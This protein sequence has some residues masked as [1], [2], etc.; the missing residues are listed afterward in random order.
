MYQIR[1]LCRWLAILSVTLMASS[2]AH[3]PVPH[4]NQI[5][6]FDGYAYDLLQAEQGAINQGK[7]ELSNGALPAKA[8]EPL[9][10]AIRQY[11]LA[12]S[13][14]KSWRD[15]TLA[16]NCTPEQTQD[17]VQNLLDALAAA[18]SQFKLASGGK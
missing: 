3:K 12:Q 6:S 16:T 7:Q 17:K 10:Y 9:N 14:W 15:C 8:K 18:I 4:P 11:D 1:R 2:C 5:N 13:A